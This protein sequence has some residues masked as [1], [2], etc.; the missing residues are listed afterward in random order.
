MSLKNKLIIYLKNKLSPSSIN[1]IKDFG[2]YMLRA[3]WFAMYPYARFVC[4]PLNQLK[5]KRKDERRLEIG[6]GPRRVPGFETINVVWGRD[7]D[8]IGDAS[9]R[10]PFASG[11]FDLIYASHVLEHIPWYQLPSVIKEWVRI[12]KPGGS[13]EIWIPNGLLIAQTFV[14]AEL[15]IKNEIDKDGWFKFNEGHDPCVWANGRIFSYG[16]GTGRKNDPN[17]HMAVFSPRY[18]RSLLTDSG[19]INI[20]ELNSSKVRGYDH[21]WI[22]L[23]MKGYKQ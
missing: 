4:T 5:N 7:V 21:G 2:S 18:L 1:R 3:F 23:G 15:G 10:L 11:T 22:N 12:L 14:N 9:K 13:I 20:D 16:D 17:W 8:Y 6:P 19:L